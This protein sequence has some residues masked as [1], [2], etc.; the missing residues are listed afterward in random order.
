LAQVLQALS[1]QQAALLQA[2]ADG[3]RLQRVVVEH[4]LDAGMESKP[5][6]N[7]V[8]ELAATSGMPKAPNSTTSLPPTVESAPTPVLMN[9]C[10]RPATSLR[11]LHWSPSRAHCPQMLS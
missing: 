4:M 5:P 8:P 10:S 3:M 6:S 1:Q 11:S 7:S 2:H 9:R